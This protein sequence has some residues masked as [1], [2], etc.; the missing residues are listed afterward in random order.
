[1]RWPDPAVP[2]RMQR[3]ALVAPEAALREVLASVADAAIMQ[4]DRESGP[5]RAAGIPGTGAGL[6]GLPADTRPRGPAAQPASALISATLPDVQEL[7]RSGRY[8][9]L[10]GE[11]ELRD[12]AAAAMHRRDAAALVGW[13]PVGRLPEITAALADAG[14]A[15]V[16]LARPAWSQPPTLLP[17]RGLQ[18]EL[19]PLVQTYGT[20]PYADLDPSWLAWAS[21]VLMF[22]MMFGDAGQGVL[23]LAVAVALRFGWP[24]RLRRF[25]AAWPFVGGA[26]L[27]ATL[28]GLLY[29]ECFGPTGLVPIFWLSPLARPVTLLLTAAGFGAV[30][31]AGAY[32]LGT[33]NRWR[34]GGWRAALYAPSGI[35]GCCLFLGAATGLAAWHFHETGWL[36]AGGLLALAGLGLAFAGYLAEAGRGGTAVTQACVE[37]FDMVVRLGSNVVSFTRLAAFGLTHA[38]LGLLIFEGTRALWHRGGVFTVAGVVL[39]AAGTALAFSLEALVAAIQALRLEY[40]EL[41]SRVFVAQGEPF[42]PWHVPVAREAEQ[43]TG[44]LTRTLDMEVARP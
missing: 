14:G 6:A 4:I 36:A 7:E 44:K 18:H 3:V 5:R 40:Y 31:L 16:P 39:F 2:V 22:G 8:D 42:R 33:I 35:A 29:G 19:A 30:L 27:A 43:D 9:L 28:F 11:A 15:V 37:L 32:A 13:I 20:V 1:M 41:F 12:H 26:G 24:R 34:E 21:Y 23:L 10:A 25:R 17:E 38:A